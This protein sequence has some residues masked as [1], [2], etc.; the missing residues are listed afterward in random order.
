MRADGRP[1]GDRNLS[2]F[3][4]WLTLPHTQRRHSYQGSTGSGNL[5]QCRFKSFAVETG[6]H[7]LTQGLYVERNA[8]RAGLAQRAEDWPLGSLWQRL[9][10]D[11]EDRPEL[12]DGPIPLPTTWAERV[13]GPQTRAEEETLRRCARRG[14]PV[15][16][17]AWAHNTVK[18]F[19]LQS[20]RCHPGRPPRPSHPG[21][22]LIFDENGSRHQ[23]YSL[24]RP[25]LHT[26]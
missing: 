4:S 1:E 7:L 13:N 15:G 14:Q 6:E 21:Q 12:A 17:A 3:V 2:P 11:A 8:L 5:Y 22:L 26:D 9:Y 16:T 25:V 23:F 20:T 10:G 24:V 19:G 18:S